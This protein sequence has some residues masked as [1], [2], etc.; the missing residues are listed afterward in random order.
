MTSIDLCA[1]HIALTFAEEI[2]PGQCC[3]TGEEGDTLPRA[4]GIKGTFTNLDLLAAPQSRRVGVPAAKCLNHRPLRSCWIATK[5]ALI[6]APKAHVRRIVL[7]SPP[8]SPWACYVT[9][10]YKKHGVLRAPVN[11]PNTVRILFETVIADC[12]DREQVNGWWDRLRDAQDKG[13]PRSV[14]ERGV[15]DPYLMQKVGWQYAVDFEAWAAPKTRSPAYM[16]LCYLLPSK[17]ELN[18]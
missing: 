3:V 6:D 12:S 14:I 18:S 1:P 9:T 4:A 2:Q 7:D 17:E 11:G 10:S 8:L 13:L 5:D 16:L 15:V